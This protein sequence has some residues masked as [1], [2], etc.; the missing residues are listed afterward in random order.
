MSPNQEQIYTYRMSHK[1][2]AGGSGCLAAA[3][4]LIGLLLL[5][6]VLPIGLLF[7]AI[8]ITVDVKT[9]TITTCGY[10][11]NEVT[12]TSVLCPTC[13]AD[14]AAPTAAMRRKDTL[15]QVA[16]TVL[17]LLIITVVIVYIIVK[18]Q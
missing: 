10:C 14:L 6:P 9:K 16:K 5:I 7:I 2:R 18:R 15:K 11:G 17:L 1:V 4:L 13:H 12:K 3:C 8:G